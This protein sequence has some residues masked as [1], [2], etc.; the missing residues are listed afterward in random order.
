MAPLP[1][2][3]LGRRPRMGADYWGR[4]AW[5]VGAVLVVFTGRCVRGD[6]EVFHSLG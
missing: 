6:A 3:R 1:A 2:H 4:A 5:A